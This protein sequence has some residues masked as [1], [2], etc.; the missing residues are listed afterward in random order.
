L[1]PTKKAGIAAGVAIGISLA[2]IAWMTLARN[3][4]VN[5]TADD[6]EMIVADMPPQV[7]AELASNEQTRKDFAKDIKELVAVAEEAKATGI[8]NDPST[9]KQMRLNEALV[10]AQGYA[11]QG[12]KSLNELVTEQELAA[13]FK[14]PGQ[15]QNFEQFLKDAQGVFLSSVPEGPQKD[16]IKNQWAR[17]QLAERKAKQ[18]GF[19][20]Q[21]KVQLQV[22]FQQ[23]RL[24]AQ[25][26]MQNNKDK[27][28]PTDAELDAY[29]AKNP[30][31]DDKKLKGKAEDIL[32]RAR[33]G[34]DFNKLASEFSGDPGSKEKG[35]DLGW[36]GRGAMVKP[37]EEA[38][39]ALQAGQISNV[40]ESDFGYHIIKVE[41]RKTEKKDGKDEEQVHARHI[42][43]KS[44][45]PEDQQN[46]YGPPQKPREQAK[47]VL[48]QEKRKKFIEDVVKKRNI[49]VAENFKVV[50]PAQP[51]GMPP[52]M[53]G[54]PM[55]G[56][57]DVPPPPNSKP[58]A[59]KLP[60]EKPKK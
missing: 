21:R 48:S 59:E 19:D 16:Q 20:K 41:G 29:I 30:Q 8:A 49:T 35:G 28:N 10:I 24:L 50:A 43:I 54:P 6:L 9:V 51:P 23:A 3:S 7:R 11:T 18:A 14:E 38:A 2:L 37:F 46:P 60:A 33:A 31:Y 13:F 32:K 15:D 44:D 25:K 55:P 58:P 52:G 56:Q 12:K 34:E 36:F 42:L 40:V 53:Q 17:V 39:F 5:L 4:G 45:A 27:F 1:T 22:M 47:T 57:G 26:Y